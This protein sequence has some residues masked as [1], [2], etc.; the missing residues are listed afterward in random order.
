MSDGTD[1]Y[2]E[3][4][5]GPEWATP[6]YLWEPLGAALGGFDLDPASGC[7]PVPIAAERWSL[8]NDFTPTG[9]S[10]EWGFPAKP[11]ARVSRRVADGLAQ[12]WG[13][14]CG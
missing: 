6:R 5:A 4:G 12:S 8:D 10:E 1:F 9:P 7:E 14:M 3:H 2:G 13:G 11:F